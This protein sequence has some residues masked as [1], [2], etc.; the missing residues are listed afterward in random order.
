MTDSLVYQSDYFLKPTLLFSCR[1]FPPELCKFQCAVIYISIRSYA[2][3]VEQL[4]SFNSMLSTLLI[5]R[6]RCN[7]MSHVEQ[8]KEKHA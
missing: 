2:T 7:L 5:L 4:C 3:F 8:M 6:L 1:I